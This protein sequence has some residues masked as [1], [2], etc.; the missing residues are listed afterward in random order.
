[1]RKK[2]RLSGDFELE[3]ANLNPKALA[4]KRHRNQTKA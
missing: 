4:Q 3:T 2:I 1:M